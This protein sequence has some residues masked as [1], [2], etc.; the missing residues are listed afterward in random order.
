MT[1]LKRASVAAACVLGATA[2]LIGM[3]TPAFA[4][5][6]QAIYNCDDPSTPANP[7]YTATTDWTYSAGSLTIDSDIVTPQDLAVGQV[8]A[9]INGTS[10]ANTS[11]LQT[12]DTVSLGPKAVTG[13]ISAPN[14]LVLTIN[15]PG[16]SVTCTLVSSTGFPLI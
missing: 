7:D 14:P 15:P 12:G 13:P 16:I 4:A 10:V 11:A 3:S 8:S 9:T 1:K 5:T 6:A 2:G